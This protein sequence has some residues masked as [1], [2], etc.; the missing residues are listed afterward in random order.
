MAL[1][2]ASGAAHW[3]PLSVITEETLSTL[4]QAWKIGEAVPTVMQKAQAMMAIQGARSAASLLKRP[5]PPAGEV[6]KDSKGRKVKMS[7][8][9]AQGRDDE[10]DIVGDDIM[11]TGYR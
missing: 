5:L 3:R 7:L 2:G 6:A 9:A 11:S 8:V 4:L 1:L 10:V